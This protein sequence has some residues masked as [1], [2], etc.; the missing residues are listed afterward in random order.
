VT[1]NSRKGNTYLQVSFEPVKAPPSSGPATLATPKH[2]PN[3]PCNI[4]LLASGTVF[5]IIRIAPV[6]IPD[7]PKPATALPIINIRLLVAAPHIALPASNI[8]IPDR[9]TTLVEKKVYT[10]P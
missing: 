7:D 2:A 5:N 10:R 4:G 6:K 3:S 8:N 1:S 9:K